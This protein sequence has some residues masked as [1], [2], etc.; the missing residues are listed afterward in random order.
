MGRKD[1][2]KRATAKVDIGVLILRS[3]HDKGEW[4]FARLNEYF[5]CLWRHANH[6]LII[7]SDNEATSSYA[8]TT[9][10]CTSLN[11]F[12]ERAVRVVTKRKAEHAIVVEFCDE[13]AMLV[14]HRLL[15]LSRAW[16]SEP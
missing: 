16:V 4:P 6:L 9:S 13:D 12:H 1:Q 3:L 14:L 2:T 10:R 15:G 11:A 5:D 8:F 7:H